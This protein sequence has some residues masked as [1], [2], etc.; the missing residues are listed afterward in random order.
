MEWG[1]IDVKVTE[2]VEPMVGW[3]GIHPH[4]VD[5][6]PSVIDKYLYTMFN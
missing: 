5:W 1:W 6:S 3:K 4:S 2:K